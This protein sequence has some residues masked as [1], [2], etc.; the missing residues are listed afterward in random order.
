MKHKIIL[1]LLAIS[2][3]AEAQFDP[4]ALEDITVLSN[5]NALL[6]E[7]GIEALLALPDIFSARD[8]DHIENPEEQE[9]KLQE[10]KT[11]YNSIHN[12]L[13]VLTH[14]A[15]IKHQISSE[16]FHGRS[17]PTRQR[18]QRQAHR[19][20]LQIK[21]PQLQTLE[22][23]LQ[24]ISGEDFDHSQHQFQSLSDLGK[25]NTEKLTDTK[26]SAINTFSPSFSRSV[27]KSGYVS[28]PFL[29][30]PSSS[31]LNGP[32][33]SLKTK[34]GEE[35]V[36]AF[37][38]EIRR[39]NHEGALTILRNSTKTEE[40]L[41]EIRREQR[42][43]ELRD[44]SLQFVYRYRSAQAFDMFYRENT[45][46][47]EEVLPFLNRLGIEEPTPY[48]IQK[49]LSSSYR[50]ASPSQ[51]KSNA[52]VGFALAADIEFELQRTGQI[53]RN[54]ILSPYSV[55]ATLRYQ[56]D[57]IKAPD[58]QELQSLS[59][60]IAEGNWGMD[61]GLYTDNFTNT[62]FCLTSSSEDT[63]SPTGYVS[64]KNMEIYKGEI[65]FA[66]LKAMIDHRKPPILLID[67]AAREEIEDWINITE[68]GRFTHVLVVVG[69]GT[70]DIDP[71]TLR[72]GPYFLVRDSLAS[73]PIH[74]KVSAKDLLDN[75]LGILKTTQL[76]RH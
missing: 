70:E 43:R 4:A 9:K 1:L 69:Y 71:F 51:A 44:Y 29:T 34:I 30:S 42:L 24:I 22:Q 13:F 2:F 20:K 17:R 5:Q 16:V 19:N 50:T 31:I 6:Y 67:S 60:T 11:L 39:G 63:T 45:T 10:W 62:N 37:I 21:R 32:L 38:R 64:I 18:W 48:F 8:F 55:Y 40:E 52:C 27:S 15:R 61:V 65:T 23:V 25:I 58:C 14:I 53:R 47:P 73:Q 41:K 7:E 28:N 56:E 54:E 35:N 66:L 49:D 3:N 75:S 12:R 46:F 26:G 74:Y 36:A 68:N 59:N 33:S 57:G 72:K 76:E